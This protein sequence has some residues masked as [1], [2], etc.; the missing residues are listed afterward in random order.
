MSLPSRLRVVLR[1]RVL[2]A[3][4]NRV[5]LEAIRMPPM[6]YLEKWS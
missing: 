4:R 1:L 6:M 5:P 3:H 2:K